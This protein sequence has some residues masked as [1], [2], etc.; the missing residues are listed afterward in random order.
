MRQEELRGGRPFDP[1][2]AYPRR[3]KPH[4][5]AI[6]AR[7]D[8]P[9]G[10]DPSSNDLVPLAIGDHVRL[11]YAADDFPAG[12]EAVVV[13][14]HPGED[15]GGVLLQIE[16]DRIGLPA[17]HDEDV[18]FDVVVRSGTRGGMQANPRFSLADVIARAIDGQDAAAAAG[19]ADFMRHRMG[20]DYAESFRMVQKVRPAV[21]A[22]EWD[23]ILAEA[24][25]SG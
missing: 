13:D 11:R 5:F 22:A 15:G 17:L 9:I 24:D 7:I 16:R 21:T 2:R 4:H 19:A 3:T 20:L 1:A 23:A 10:Y 12:T 8:M 6:N 25:V 14:L 18:F